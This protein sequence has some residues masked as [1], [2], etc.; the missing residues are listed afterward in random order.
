LRY[1]DEG[2]SLAAADEEAGCD[3]ED[4]IGGNEPLCFTGL[5]NGLNLIG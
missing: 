3:V 5:G 2:Y 1:E 4:L